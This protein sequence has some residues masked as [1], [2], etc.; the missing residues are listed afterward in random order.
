MLRISA[1]FTRSTPPFYLYKPKFHLML[2]LVL[3]RHL[4]RGLSHK[5]GILLQ[6][7]LFTELFTDG[8]CQ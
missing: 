1:T 8:T 7:E 2:H 5:E 3:Q 4:L 6:S